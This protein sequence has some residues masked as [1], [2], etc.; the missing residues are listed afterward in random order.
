MQNDYNMIANLIKNMA[1]NAVDATVPV[2]ILTGKVI[3]E[4]PLQ[5]ALDSK[6]II[7]E[8]RIKLTKNTSDWTAEISVDHITE[9]RA[10]GGGYALFESHNHEY[11]GRKKFLIHNALKVGDEVW[12]I[13]ETGGQRFIAMDRVY[14]PNTGC[15]TK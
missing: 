10:G 12:L 14:N 9:N 1:V 4:V 11:K 8:E 5:I 3:S 15:T 6:M 2:T 7:P 13:R